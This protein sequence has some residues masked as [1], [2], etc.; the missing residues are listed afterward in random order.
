[1]YSINEVVACIRAVEVVLIVITLS[2]KYQMPH[3]YII[4]LM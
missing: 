2:F 3:W 1:M 4:Y